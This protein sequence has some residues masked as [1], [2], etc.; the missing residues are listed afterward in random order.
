MIPPS[1]ALLVPLVL[2]LVL[3]RLA[4]PKAEEAPQALRQAIG[5][6]AVSG[7]IMALVMGMHLAESH[8]GG[9]SIYTASD[10]TQYCEAVDAVRSGRPWSINPHRSRLA[11]LL[12]GLVSGRLG[13]VDGLSLSAL[14]STSSLLGGLYLWAWALRGR[15]AAVAAVLLAG[16]FA[17][18]VLLTRTLSFYPQTCAGYVLAGAA[19][20]LAIRYR[21][22]PFLALGAFAPGLAVLLNPQGV[23]WALPALGVTLLAALWPP[24]GSEAAPG[25]WRFLGPRVLLVGAVIS[26]TWFAGRFVYASEDQA[27]FE[28]EVFHYVETLQSQA[29]ASGLE[30]TPLEHCYPSTQEGFVWGHGAPWS[31]LP[32]LRCTT[33]LQSQIPDGLHEL[34]GVRHRYVQRL[35]PWWFVMG[36]GLLVAVLGLLRRPAAFLGLVPNLVPYAL[37]LSHAPVDSSARRLAVGMAVVPVVLG[38]A[39]AV[40]LEDGPAPPWLRGRRGRVLRGLRP[41]VVW[42]AL[43]ALVTGLIPSALSPDASWR[44]PYLTRPGISE[45]LSQTPSSQS[46]T[47]CKVAL[48]ADMARGLPLAGHLGEHYEQ[49]RP[50]P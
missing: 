41:W 2:L 13:I 5:W 4:L 21:T 47:M 7:T 50:Q 24:P 10:F 40:L 44:W 31:V 34:Q 49:A 16:A 19:S 23:I 39:F 1:W 35:Q 20:A 25:R 8:L 17:P 27:S 26:C 12:P 3:C 32:A 30:V 9:D 36:L 14:L 38:V 43:A 42:V 28:T 22:R 29:K 11:A 45:V 37:A 15:S 46:W 18:L 33:E 6:A 48:E